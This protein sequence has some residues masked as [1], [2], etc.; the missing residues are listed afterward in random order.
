MGMSGV[1]N[2][3]TDEDIL[4]LEQNFNKRGFLP[5]DWEHGSVNAPKVPIAGKVTSL[6]TEGWRENGIWGK[7][8]LNPNGV[9]GVRDMEYDKTSPYF[10]KSGKRPKDILSIGL[11]RIPDFPQMAPVQLQAASFVRHMQAKQGEKKM[12]EKLLQRLGLPA[13]ATA[14]QVADKIDELSKLAAKANEPS[15]E[16]DKLHKQLEESN[17][18]MVK[19]QEELYALKTESVLNEADHMLQAASAA[20]KITQKQKELY[21]RDAAKNGLVWLKEHLE[22]FPVER[23]VHGMSL[24]AASNV[25]FD[26]NLDAVGDDGLTPEERALVEQ[27]GGDVNIMIEQRKKAFQKRGML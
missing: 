10:A 5:I 19:F 24:Q 13:N 22:A 14:D 16:L 17:A 11:V 7:A 9:V 12:D 6:I 8:K 2:E 3:L 26:S 21:L 1:E 27:M 18:R 20:R 4:E 15:G 25:R 23:P